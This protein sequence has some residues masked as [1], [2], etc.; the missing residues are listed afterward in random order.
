MPPLLLT[1]RA[2][3]R[4][5]GV[6]PRHSR[7]HEPKKKRRRWSGGNSA[8]VA[9]SVVS[10]RAMPRLA[11]CA[12][13][14]AL[15]RAAPPGV[16]R[17]SAFAIPSARA[18]PAPELGAS[19]GAWAAARA[20]QRAGKEPTLTHTR[21]ARVCAEALDESLVAPSAGWPDTLL[22]RVLHVPIG[23]PQRD[24]LLTALLRGIWAAPHNLAGGTYARLLRRMRGVPLPHTRRAMHGH[25]CAGH[26]PDPAVWQALLRLHAQA[27]DWARMDEI[28][29]LGMEGGMLNAADE[30][31]YTLLR[32]QHDPSAP[33]PH[34]SMD[35][36]LQHMQQSGLRLND[37][38]LVRLLHAL[39]APVRRAAAAH[40]ST[41]RMAQKVAPVQRLV[42]AFFVWLCH[43]DALPLAAFRRSLAH[44]LELELELLAA[45]HQAVMSEAR[46]VHRPCS[47]FPPRTSLQKVQAKLALVSDTLRGDDGLLERVQIAL[48][49]TSGRSREATAKLQAWIARDASDSARELQR[50]ALVHIFSQ[51]CRHARPRR[52]VPMLHVLAAGTS[53]DLWCP[54]A[55]RTAAPPAATLV[56][57]WTRFV[58]AWT[59]LIG[60]RRGRRTRERVAQTAMGWPLVARTLDLLTRTASQVPAA[61][62][63]VWDHPER[64]RALVTAA[65]HAPSLSRAIARV[66][67]C[68]RT[69]QVPGRIHRSFQK[70]VATV[71]RYP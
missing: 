20:L 50:R 56:R 19:R 1:R 17:T 22:R 49:A 9:A 64:C 36:L 8:D 5:E 38:M 48:D 2:R 39:V 47:P 61:W 44:M 71:P 57:L 4:I 18:L 28:L 66:D 52:L 21:A 29:R 35:V 41:E 55:A 24:M 31:H 34:N 54:P 10:L 43:H 59:H 30:Y 3:A 14:C 16:R 58:G 27:H 23:A 42:D 37:A 12:G 33:H 46:R 70:A 68:L 60:V 11:G 67:E 26:L 7:W 25:V 45:Q 40:V 15:G 62:A 51:A 32:L 6:R 69:M 13:V 65:R 63:P 53:A